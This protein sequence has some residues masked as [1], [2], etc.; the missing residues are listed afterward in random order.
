[1]AQAALSFQPMAFLPISKFGQNLPVSGLVAFSQA[2][3]GLGIGLLVADKMGLVSRQRTAFALIG[4]GTAAVVPFAAGVFARFKDRPES[5]S[6]MRRQ[7]N[8]IRGNASFDELEEI[9]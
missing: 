5:S 7:L 8:S 3:V 9:V 1:M 4:A 6:R 2:A